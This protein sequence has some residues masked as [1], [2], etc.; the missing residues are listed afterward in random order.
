[1]RLFVTLV[2]GLRCMQLSQAGTVATDALGIAA[3]KLEHLLTYVLSSG[4]LFHDAFYP[5]ATYRLAMR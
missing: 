1:M 5:S 2:F 3:D 4:C